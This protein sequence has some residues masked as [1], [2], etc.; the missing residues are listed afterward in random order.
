[1]K[2]GPATE[3]QTTL[4]NGVAGQAWVD[5][6][7]VLDEM[8]RPAEALLVNTAR[9]AS[10]RRVLDVGCGTGGTTLALAGALGAQTQCLGADLSAPMIEAARQ[11]AVRERSTAQFVCVD[12]QRHAFGMAEFELI[13]SR[14]G[15]MFFDDPVQAFANLRGAAR[16][17]A[18][19]C[20]IAWRSPAENPFMTTAERAAAPLL[21][22][23]P[24]R[25]PDTPGQFA[26]AERT[27]VQGI[28]EDS[29]WRDIDIR[30]IDFECR[31]PESALRLYLS[32]LGPVGRLLQEI[33]AARRAQVIEVIRAAF[34]PHVRGD[35]VHFSAACWQILARAA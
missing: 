6:Q 22:E 20:A 18:G 33:D 30:A 15:V 32:R 25:K 24:A 35:E 4:W 19:L 34:E 10:A 12:A 21:P 5:A 8:F 7:A 9:A 26:F 28:L 3:D 1:M 14:F 29:G 23:L 11:R 27:R 17:D 13:V 2:A 31:F 16:S